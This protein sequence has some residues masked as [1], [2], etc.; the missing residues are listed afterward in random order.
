MPFRLPPFRHVREFESAKYFAK[1]CAQIGPA[2]QYPRGSGE[3][4]LIVD[5]E[6][7][8]L[9]ITSATLEQFGYKSLTASNGAEALDIFGRKSSEIAAV[10]TDIAMP[11]MDG[12][13]LIRAVKSFD[14]EVKVIAMSGLMN[15]DQTEELEELRVKDFL[16]KPFTAEQLLTTLA[17]LLR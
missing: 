16:T 9:R 6:P 11:S 5:D 12:P 17:A 13:S 3:T 1:W 7:N 2:S 8:I 15:S 4:V 10:V 14:S